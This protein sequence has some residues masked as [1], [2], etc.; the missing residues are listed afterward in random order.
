MMLDQYGTYPHGYI[1][2]HHEGHT[3]GEG[4]D[5]ITG[6]HELY[7][8]INSNADL[9]KL[10]MDVFEYALAEFDKFG[11]FINFVN[12]NALYA[13][14]TDHGYRFLQDTIKFIETGKRDIDILSWEYLLKTSDIYDKRQTGRS[15]IRPPVASG[16]VDGSIAKWISHDGGFLDMLWSLK[17]LFGKVE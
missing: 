3:D 6:L 17:I 2:F 13:K 11:G 9:R 14:L 10:R 15:T 16:Y 1:G 7:S 5:K 8:A 4:C 12:E